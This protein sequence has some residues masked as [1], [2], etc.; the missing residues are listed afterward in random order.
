MSNWTS[1]K[2]WVAIK[3]LFNP[4][5]KCDR[6]GHIYIIQSKTIRKTSSA[7]RT[8][9]DDYI[10]QFNVC[11]R[12]GHIVGEPFNLVHVDWYSSCTMPSYMWD[13]MRRQGYLILAEGGE[14]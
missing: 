13:K 3:E 7:Y 4:A 11:D 8:V 9:V 14:P 2:I 10:A 12:C 6:I 5:L 1:V